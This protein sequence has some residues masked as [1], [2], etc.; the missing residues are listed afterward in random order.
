MK[1][2]IIAAIL[3]AASPGMAQNGTTACASCAAWNAPQ[4]PYRVYG[5]TYYVG[6][7][8]LSAILIAS[9]Q[10]LILIDGDLP[11]SAPQ[12][13]DHIRT[14]GFRLKDIRLILNSHT[15][16]DHAGG[17]AKLQSLS[18]A[19]VG[20]SPW[21]A[22]VLRTGGTGRDDPQYE[23]AP[24]IAPVSRVETVGD[25]QS[26][27]IG[28]L[29]ITAHFTPGHTPGGTSWTWQS[30]EKSRCLQVVYA[31]SL[32]PVSADKYRFRDHPALLAGFEK[33]FALLDSLPCDILLTPH[34]EFS[35]MAQRLKAHDAGQADAFVDPNACRAYAASARKALAKRLKQEESK[36]V[37][38]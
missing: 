9:D 2:L 25:G 19:R 15:H 32:T 27:Q 22:E 29:A 23:F 26:L 17:I 8:E 3:L 5:N 28:S 12:I 13:A 7:K 35:N 6:T 16:F 33:S 38:K 24:G 21:S 20:A 11:Q 34:P 36:P 10:G 18:G 4:Q 31:D 1:R 30:C 37:K 14:L